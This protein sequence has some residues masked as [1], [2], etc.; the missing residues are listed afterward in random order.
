ML[1]VHVYVEARDQ[2]QVSFQYLGEPF[3]SPLFK[4]NIFN[5]FVYVCLCKYQYVH[6]GIGVLGA[7]RHWIH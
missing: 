5:Y 3:T 1:C 2:D 6:V 7:Q 4:K